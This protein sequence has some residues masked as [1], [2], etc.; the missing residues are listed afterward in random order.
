MT[1]PSSRGR[2]RALPRLEARDSVSEKKAIGVDGTGEL[3]NSNIWATPQGWV[4][5]RDAAASSTYLLDPHNPRTRIQLPHLPEDN[6]PPVCTCLLSGYP[7]DP[8][9]PKGCLVLLIELDNPIIRY[10]RIGGGGGDGDEWVKHEYDIGTLDLPEGSSEKLVMCSVAACN[11]KFYFNGGFD[12]LGVLE[13]GGPVA[14]AF[15][16][17]AIRD[18]VE[19]LFMVSLLSATDLNVSTGMDF[20]RQ[21][22]R[23][24]GDIGGRAFLL[25]PWYFGAS[26]KRLM[27]F[28]VKDGTTK[29]QDLDGAPVSE[30]ALWML[31]TNP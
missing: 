6:L 31:P 10:C 15:S 17:V 14:P 21:E 20:S 25:S 22:W 13:F 24:V 1:T 28:N 16:S 23:E 27:V 5:V 3:K 7:D 29:M 18:A 8:A 11:G 30:L 2:P 19:E 4:L 12:E 9:N 26:T